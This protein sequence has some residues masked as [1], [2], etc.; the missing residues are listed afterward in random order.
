MK[1][2]VELKDGWSLKKAGE[3]REWLPVRNMPAQVQDILYDHGLLSEEFWDG[4]KKHFLSGNQTGY[5]DAVLPVRKAENAGCFSG[6]WT[7]WRT[8]G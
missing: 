5:T 7:P 2:N 1:T 3:D 6:D 8:S 4:V